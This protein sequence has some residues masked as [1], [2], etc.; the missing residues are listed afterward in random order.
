[1]LERRLR[2]FD[3]FPGCTA[4]LGDAI[5]KCWRACVVPGAGGAP[6]EVLAVSPEGIRVACGEDALQLTEL[7]R[8]G[9]R[10]LTAREFALRGD[11]APGMRFLPSSM[12]DTRSAEAQS[13]C[14]RR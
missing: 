10:R 2:A 4:C 14:V 12:P 8:P 9:G 7:Q 3:P 11:I 1:M 5:V 6:G 13:R